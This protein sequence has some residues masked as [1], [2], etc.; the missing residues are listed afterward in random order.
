MGYAYDL[1]SPSRFQLMHPD[2]FELRPKT[3]K[4]ADKMQHYG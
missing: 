1:S 3:H 4:S 2:P